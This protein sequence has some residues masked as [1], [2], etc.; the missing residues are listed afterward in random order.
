M[1]FWYPH[2]NVLGNVTPSFN[3]QNF[4][5]SSLWHWFLSTRCYFTYE[6][7]P[8]E[9]EAPNTGSA[10]RWLNE[11]ASEWMSEN[12]PTYVSYGKGYNGGFGVG[13]CWEAV[14]GTSPKCWPPKVAPNL[15]LWFP[16]VA[17]GSHRGSSLWGQLW[18]WPL[19]W[20]TLQ[21]EARPLTA[22]LSCLLSTQ[23][24]A[25]YIIYSPWLHNS[26][27]TNVETEA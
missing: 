4:F 13:G 7:S 27:S 11:R 25:W 10:Q 1:P 23:H 6:L 19:M 2:L 14:M 21:D 24:R 17:G 9:P 8:L 20:L 5:G 22:S 16:R 26:A 15:G 18:V 3:A 12:E